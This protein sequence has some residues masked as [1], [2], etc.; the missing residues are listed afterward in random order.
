MRLIS[1]AYC[2]IE[3]FRVTKTLPAS[4]RPKTAAERLYRAMTQT[5]GWSKS[6]NATTIAVDGPAGTAHLYSGDVA[7]ALG[8]G[9]YIRFYVEAYVGQKPSAGE[10]YTLVFRANEV[11]G[12]VLNCRNFVMKLDG[13]TFDLL[14]ADVDATR[15]RTSR[16]RFNNGVSSTRLDVSLAEL[17]RIA[18]ATDVEATWCA[19]D[20]ILTDAPARVQ[21]LID[22]I[23]EGRARSYAETA[24]FRD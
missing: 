15:V 1:N 11:G 9:E 12:S 17:E 5:S 13:E 23:D 20:I 24:P 6:P 8:G 18:A 22:A 4:K 19:E 2:D 3:T 14:A 7:G 10:R 21:E 16:R